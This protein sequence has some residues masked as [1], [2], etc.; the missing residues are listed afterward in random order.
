MLPN[1]TFEI[2]NLGKLDKKYVRQYFHVKKNFIRDPST[3]DDKMD[4]LLGFKRILEGF[5]LLI[6]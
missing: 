3:R 6:N 5:L 2:C 1:A 4:I